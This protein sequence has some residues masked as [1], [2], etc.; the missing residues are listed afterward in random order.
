MKKTL[1]AIRTE[2]AGNNVLGG[3]SENAHG[4]RNKTVGSREKQAMKPR[5]H[6]D[7]IVRPNVNDLR[8]SFGDVRY[9]FNAVA[10][11]DALAGHLYRWCSSSASHEV[12]GVRDDSAYRE[13]L[14][15][16]NADFALVRDIAKA[17]KHVQ[18]TRGSPKV[19]TAA[20]VE[21]RS[22][23]WGEARWGEGRWG[24]PPQVVV[25]TNAGE[26]RVV[27]SIVDRALRFLEAEM[28][29]LRVP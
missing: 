17:Q 18:L 10:A 8:T 1:F 15:Q 19:S 22:L 20:Q 7:L 26:F 9:A 6:L 13:Q 23:G 24:S 29:R 28:K 2:E 3:Y 21:T 4:L 14:A 16:S 11:V 27:V 12:A 5:D 25:Q